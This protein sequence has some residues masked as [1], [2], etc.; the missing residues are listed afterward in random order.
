MGC[1]NKTCGLTRLHIRMGEPVYVFAL[2][3][4]DTHERCY[5]TAFWKPCLT[6]W[7]AEYNDHGA[8]ENDKGVGYKF[9]VDGIKKGL[10]ELEEGENRYH[11]IPVK[12]E[13]FDLEKFYKAVHK[14]RLQYKTLLRKEV[15]IDFVMM[16]KSV[17]DDL[18]NTWE[19]DGY[20]YNKDTSEMEYYTYSYDDLLDEI[21]LFVAEV[22]ELLNS[23]EMAKFRFFSSS[24]GQVLKNVK[25]ISEHIGD[26]MYRYSSILNTRQ[27]LVAMIEAGYL[28]EAEELLKYYLKGSMLNVFFEVTRRNWGPA[29]HEGSQADELDAQELLLDITK[30]A[31][32]R[33]RSYFEEDED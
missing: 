17:V 8:G 18:L 21:P 29:G 10:V 9:V 31:I 6:P 14:G 4:A 20:R 15:P 23:D 26:T 11:D 28:D 30:E 22:K 3:R 27:T 5:A 16:K 2:E 25:F 7:E 24:L 1:W 19:I 33:E 12:K 32:A 13:G